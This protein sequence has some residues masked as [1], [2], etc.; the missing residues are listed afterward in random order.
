V[1]SHYRVVMWY[2]PRYSVIPGY[3]SALHD[4][5][6]GYSHTANNLFTYMQFGGHIWIYGGGVVTQMAAT[7]SIPYPLVGTNV[8]RVGTFCADALGLNGADTLSNVFLADRTTPTH[9]T[10]EY[11]PQFHDMTPAPVPF[12]RRTAFGLRAAQIPVM[13]FDEARYDTLPA[14]RR[15]DHFNV[16]NLMPNVCEYMRGT[17]DNVSAN[18][19]SAFWQPIAL[20][21]AVG[22]L[23][24][25]TV[26]QGKRLAVEGSVTGWYVRGTTLLAPQGFKVRAPYELY[27]FGVP[28]HLL[29]REQVRGLADIILSTD[30]WNI[31]RGGCPPAAGVKP[32]GDAASGSGGRDLGDPDLKSGPHPQPNPG[33]AGDQAGGHVQSRA[34]PRPLEGQVH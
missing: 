4:M 15:G 19:D 25:S 10:P 12:V 13:D 22:P 11:N 28:L 34:H 27:C 33:Q 24:E 31:W 21:H 26:F 2:S 30:G 16:S 29:N 7:S 17:P 14:G 5:V 32:P 20:Y 18:R 9:N 23:A 8:T 1:L 3:R 6:T